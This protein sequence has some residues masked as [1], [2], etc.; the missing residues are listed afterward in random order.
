MANIQAPL[1]NYPRPEE[2]LPRP[3]TPQEKSLHEICQSF[4]KEDLKDLWLYFTWNQDESRDTQGIRD[5]V[6]RWGKEGKDS[7]LDHG[8]HFS[9]NSKSGE[10]FLDDCEVI[11]ECEQDSVLSYISWYDESILQAVPHKGDTLLLD[12]AEMSEDMDKFEDNHFMHDQL[13]IPPE[14]RPSITDVE[15]WDLDIITQE[16]K[17]WVMFSIDTIGEKYTTGSCCYGKIFIENGRLKNIMIPYWCNH[18]NRY[19][20]HKEVSEKVKYPYFGCVKW[21]GPHCQ[22]PWRLQ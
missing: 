2:M 13:A 10:W 15:Q 17:V 1:P 12:L 21:M 18:E 22:L 6:M 5:G 4:S 3:E 11:R 7:P 8:N 14:S 20:S 19:L 9:M 16:N